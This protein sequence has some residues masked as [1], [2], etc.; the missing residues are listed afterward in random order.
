MI[1]QRDG[2]WLRDGVAYPTLADALGSPSNTG[3]ILTAAAWRWLSASVS[4]IEPVGPDQV[5][6]MAEDVW[7]RE[8]RRPIDGGSADSAPHATAER[9]D[10]PANGW[11]HDAA[12]VEREDGSVELMLWTELSLDVYEQVDSGRLAYASILA[13]LEDDGAQLHSLALTNMPADHRVAPATVA[14]VRGAMTP[15]VGVESALTRAGGPMNDQQTS[16]PSAPAD[17]PAETKREGMTP[18]EMAAKLEELAGKIAALEAA[19]AARTAELAA[20]RTAPVETAEQAVERA[21]RAGKI[22]RA[23]RDAWTHVARA[24]RDVFDAHVASAPSLFDRV[25]AP[26]SKASAETRSIESAPADAVI[27]RA[28][29]LLRNAGLTRAAEGL[30]RKGG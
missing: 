25:T 4:G 6:Q 10:A 14:R 23:S 15:I 17:A 22:S 8:V 9:T 12:L 24:S 26:E 21:I 16:A 11:V 3:Q 29:D 18:E 13:S 27:S 28:Q 19:L 20:A 30:A 5:R 1:T 7:A 2:Q